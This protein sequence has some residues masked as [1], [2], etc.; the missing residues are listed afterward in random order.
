M[1]QNYETCFEDDPP[2][3]ETD[4]DILEELEYEIMNST[5]NNVL[6]FTMETDGIYIMNV[7]MVDKV[8]GSR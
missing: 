6:T 7:R 4:L 5:G 2:E 1:L 8:S 3:W